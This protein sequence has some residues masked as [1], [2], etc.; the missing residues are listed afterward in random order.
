MANTCEAKA[1]AI[2]YLQIQKFVNT[3]TRETYLTEN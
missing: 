1:A 2:I 3:T